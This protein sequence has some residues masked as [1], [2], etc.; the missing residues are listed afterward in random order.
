MHGTLPRD[1]PGLEFTITALFSLLV[2]NTVTEKMVSG[3]RVIIRVFVSTV[4]IYRVFVTFSYYTVFT[5]H[6]DLSF[7][8]LTSV[9][10][11]PMVLNSRPPV[12]CHTTIRQY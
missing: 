2:K 12:R 11:F 8:Y 4:S 10:G 7:F 9:L 5:S 1:P 3:Y 6:N